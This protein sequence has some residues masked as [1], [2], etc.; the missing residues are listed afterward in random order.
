MT[1][2]PLT[3]S[4]DDITLNP[5][6]VSIPMNEEAVVNITA[7]N[8]GDEC[9]EVL[10]LIIGVGR[11]YQIGSPSTATIYISCQL[12]SKHSNP[13]LRRVGEFKSLLRLR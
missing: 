9:A 5:L 8:D 13:S 1:V 7:L 10:E 3:A 11:G 6:P 2:R 4:T 12:P